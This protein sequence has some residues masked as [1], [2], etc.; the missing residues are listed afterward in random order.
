MIRIDCKGTV[1]HMNDILGPC[2]F[3]KTVKS[4]CICQRHHWANSLL[5]IHC[6]SHAIFIIM[7]LNMTKHYFC[8]HVCLHPILFSRIFGENVLLSLL[9]LKLLRALALRNNLINTCDV[10]LRN[11]QK[12]HMHSNRH[13]RV[14]CYRCEQNSAIHKQ[15]LT[16]MKENLTLQYYL[17][18][19]QYY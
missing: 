18:S 14:I 11:W 4:K 7:Q 1:G 3:W 6:E 10:S 2:K 9:S 17:K 12:L 13:L 15:I 19:A 16:F 5:E 8:I